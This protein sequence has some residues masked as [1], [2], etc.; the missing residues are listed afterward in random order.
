MTLEEFVNKLNS[1]AFFKEFTFYNNTFKPG[2]GGTELELA[3][4]IVWMADD[5]TILQLKERSAE[6][7]VDDASEVRWFEQKVLG[8]A[9]KQVRDTL[10][11]LDQ[12][13]T[14]TVTNGHGHSFDIRGDQIRTT[15][16]IV[17]YLPGRIVPDIVKSTRY[18]ISRTGG[19]I[20]VLDARDYLEICRTLRVP[21]DIREYFA[22]RQRLFEGNAKLVTTEPLV[23]GQYLSGD[24]NVIPTKES[25]RFLLSLQQNSAEFDISPLLASIHSQIE[26]EEN[27][28]DYYEI[29]RQFARL[30]RSGWKAAKARFL[31]C[32]EAVQKQEYRPPTR[33]VWKDLSLGFIFVPVDP[34][35]MAESNAVEL[36]ERGLLNFTH[37]HKYDQ[38]LT[39]CVGVVVAKDG[40]YFLINWCVVTFSW[41][42]NA[43]LDAMLKENSP[44]RDVNEA[45]IPRFEFE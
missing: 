32:I 20:H 19:F 3:D 43:E 29:L 42:H 1:L 9:T 12:N 34:E 13:P 44:L 35:I 30:P 37:A 25:Y 15:T 23:M 45:V 16:K 21:A 14:I 33:F 5:L 10:R 27:P 28:Y 36:M 18:Y 4:N 17:V 39:S 26:C 8:K 38:K 40:E 7:V 6:E 2:V 22:Y 11:F 24:E 31:Y 41:E